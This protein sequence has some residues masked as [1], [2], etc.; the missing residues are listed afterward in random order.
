MVI[1]PFSATSSMAPPPATLP[2][3]LRQ[4]PINTIERKRIYSFEV[5]QN[6]FVI[7]C[8][9]DQFLDGLL[10]PTYFVC[11]L[12]SGTPKMP[13]YFS[14]SCDRFLTYN[15]TI[16]TQQPLRKRYV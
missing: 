13:S 16:A 7:H 3:L 12:K 11:F 9:K 15:V 6:C 4:E 5:A 8:F 14:I 10:V 1:R 2:G